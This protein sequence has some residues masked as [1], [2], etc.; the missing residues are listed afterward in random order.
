[1]LWG[2]ID[3]SRPGKAHTLALS[4]CLFLSLGSSSSL[5]AGRRLHLVAFPRPAL[6][7]S[8]V[9]FT[10]ILGKEPKAAAV[11]A[12]HSM[13]STGTSHKPFHLIIPTLFFFFGLFLLFRAAP[14]AYGGS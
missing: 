3:F 1:M 14:W 4:K 12:R 2:W 7:Q 8:T 11:T 10:K 6:A 13:Q 5:E 9:E